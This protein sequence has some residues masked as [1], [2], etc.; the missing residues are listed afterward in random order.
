MANKFTQNDRSKQYS[1]DK[2]ARV[3][4]KR[5]SNAELVRIGTNNLRKITPVNSEYRFEEEKCKGVEI[6][7]KLIIMSDNISDIT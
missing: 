1:L 6:L 7:E 2:P 4:R 3:V 5:I